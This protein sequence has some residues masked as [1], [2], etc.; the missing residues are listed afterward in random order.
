M[1]VLIDTSVWSLA[2]RRDSGSKQLQHNIIVEEVKELINE[3]RICIIYFP[4]IFFKILELIPS[5]ISGE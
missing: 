1:K 5:G 2:L 4:I 3:T